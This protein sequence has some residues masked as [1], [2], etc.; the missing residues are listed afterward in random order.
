MD[1]VR[2]Q[3]HENFNELSKYAETMTLVPTNRLARYM[4][5]IARA[6]DQSWRSGGIVMAAS[7]GTA[8]LLDN[9][10]QRAMR[11][12]MAIRLHPA[13]NLGSTSRDYGRLAFTSED[14]ENQ[15]S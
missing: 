7:G 12:L 2:L 14:T 3:L 10:I 11:D 1:A 13:A 15:M 5:D 9:P 8:I 6:I 4:F